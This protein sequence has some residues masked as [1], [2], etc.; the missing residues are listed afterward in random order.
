[1]KEKLDGEL[2]SEMEELS[3]SCTYENVD[4]WV[5]KVFANYG[6]Q[7]AKTEKVEEKQDEIFRFSS[8]NSKTE[9]VDDVF[10]K[11]L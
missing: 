7:R 3:K 4:N 1:M 11:Y 5:D 9:K 8:D 10:G 6:R 2:Y